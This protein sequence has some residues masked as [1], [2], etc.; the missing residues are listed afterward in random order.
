MTGSQ[1]K[2]RVTSDG[3]PTITARI[4]LSRLDRTLNRLRTFRERLTS[5]PVGTG[6]S[7]FGPRTGKLTGSGC[8]DYCS[9]GSWS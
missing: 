1:M 8:H 3:T 5:V 9:G 6:V 4:T 2:T 7:I